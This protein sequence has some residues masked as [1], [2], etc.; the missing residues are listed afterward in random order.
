ME[1]MGAKRGT[2]PSHGERAGKTLQ[3]DV[4][5]GKEKSG[6]GCGK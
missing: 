4:Y 2:K 1:R 6:R 3:D 5:V